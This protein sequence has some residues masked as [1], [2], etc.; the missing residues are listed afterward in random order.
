MKIEICACN[1]HYLQRQKAAP[2]HEDKGCARS[3]EPSYPLSEGIEAEWE[4]VTAG[5]G[6]WW[7][8]P[9]S[10]VMIGDSVFTV[11][12]DDVAGF[13][14]KRQISVWHPLLCGEGSN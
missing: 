5:E 3:N 7:L 9:L 13:K 2:Q 1:H 14:D 4:G 12:D 10:L 8:G 11:L 6:M